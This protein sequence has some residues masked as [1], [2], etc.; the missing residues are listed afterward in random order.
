MTAELLGLLVPEAISLVKSGVQATQAKKLEKQYQRP[1]YDIPSGYD[2]ALNVSKEMA[3]NTQMPGFE[4]ILREIRD[5]GADNA[6]A[7]T[8]MGNSNAAVFSAGLNAENISDLI[9]KMGVTGA[10]MQNANKQNY[11]QQLGLYGAQQ[12]KQFQINEMAPYEAAKAAEAAL[13]GAAFKNLESGVNGGLNAYFTDKMIL[14]PDEYKTSAS[15]KPSRWDAVNKKN[16]NYDYSKEIG[17][18]LDVAALITG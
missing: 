5:V 10:Q 9:A 15:D 3:S 11:I 18:G 2:G 1:N 6:Y 17:A 16:G 7:S 8:E 12:D 13:R 14:N 4:N